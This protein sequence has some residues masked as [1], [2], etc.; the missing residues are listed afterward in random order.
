MTPDQ[1]NAQFGI[2]GQL[3]FGEGPGGLTFAH[4]DNGQGEALLC[5]QGAHLVSW[6]PKDQVE[7]VVWVS[8]F[9]KYAAGKSIRGGV[10]VCWPW[11]GPHKSESS[12]PGH[13]YA[14][15]VPWAVTGSAA[16]ADGAT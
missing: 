11:F 4:I 1:L 13:G 7:P 3:R 10:P 5:L 2:A 6:R 15:T 16:G 8:D 12:F 9:A 14:R